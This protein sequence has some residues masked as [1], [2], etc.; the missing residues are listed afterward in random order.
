M[1]R[2]SDPIRDYYD[3]Y[4]EFVYSDPTRYGSDRQR[5]DLTTPP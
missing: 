1:S 2:V 4:P 5:F 3:G